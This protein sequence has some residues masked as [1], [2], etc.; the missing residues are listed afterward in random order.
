[1]IRRKAQGTTDEYT[2]VS[3]MHKEIRRGDV[4]A[5]VYWSDRVAEFR[6][7]RGV[8]QYLRRILFEETHNVA[9]F[10]QWD[11][12]RSHYRLMTAQLATSRKKWEETGMRGLYPIA[13]KAHMAASSLPPIE[14]RELESAPKPDKYEFY[15][16]TLLHA[17]AKERAARLFSR[18]SKQFVEDRRRTAELLAHTLRRALFAE[19]HTDVSALLLRRKGNYELNLA[20]ETLVGLRDRSADEHAVREACLAEIRAPLRPQLYV[21]DGHTSEGRKRLNKAKLVRGQPIKGLDLRWSGHSLAI[22][23]RYTAFAEYGKRYRDVPWESVKLDPQLWRYLAA[24]LGGS[25]V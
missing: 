20:I 4:T 21:F 17:R 1:M 12:T 19:G 2:A 3:A 13:L 23:W 18:R 8:D 15:E 11:D 16:W 5:A 6:G 10:W 9:L 7:A 24:K 14:L 22:Y 25:E